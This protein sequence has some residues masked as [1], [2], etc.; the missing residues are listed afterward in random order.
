MSLNSEN[1]SNK[2]FKYV[3]TLL[4]SSKFRNGIFSVGQ[5]SFEYTYSLTYIKTL[6]NC[7]DY[8]ETKKRGE[9]IKC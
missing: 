4:F 8:K 3:D 9:R 2:I 6:K 7:I 5:C 1:M